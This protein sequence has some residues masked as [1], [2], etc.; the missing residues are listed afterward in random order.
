[1]DNIIIKHIATIQE[2]MYNGITDPKK[3]SSDDLE[4]LIIKVHNNP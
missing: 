1:M 3:A 4:L 2:S